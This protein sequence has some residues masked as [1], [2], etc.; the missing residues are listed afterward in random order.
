MQP[1]ETI[2]DT[3]SRYWDYEKTIGIKNTPDSMDFS[4]Q[5]RLIAISP[6]GCSDTMIDTVHF[7]RNFQTYNVITPDGNGKNDVFNPRVIGDK[8][9]HIMIFNR[10]GE[11]VFEST[12]KNQDWNGKNSNTGGECPA[13]TYYY[14][15]KYDL[16]GK[17]KGIGSKTGTITVIR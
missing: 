16:I 4:F 3:S 8:Y 7:R 1:D 9:Y 15:V 6:I 11:K 10:W 13:G 2:N 12:D 5:V 14:I 17:D